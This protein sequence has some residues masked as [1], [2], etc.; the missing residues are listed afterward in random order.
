MREGRPCEIG[1]KVLGPECASGSFADFL[2]KLPDCELAARDQRK[3]T[4]LLKLATL[5]GGK[6]AREVRLKRR[7]R[8]SQGAD[9]GAVASGVREARRECDAAGFQQRRQDPYHLVLAYRAVMAGHKV[10]FITAADLMLQLEYSA[11]TGQYARH[12]RPHPL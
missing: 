10:R 12:L 1:T 4:M 8:C 11:R 7:Q 5:S 9:P 2:E 3:R 6:T